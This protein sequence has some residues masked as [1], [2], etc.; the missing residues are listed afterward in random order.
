M[1]STSSNLGVSLA[2]Y[3]GE[4][5]VCLTQD[6]EPIFLLS[7]EAA[8]AVAKHILDAALELGRRTLS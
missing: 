3:D 5:Y 1:T 2:S 4:K 7:H 6:G 8:N